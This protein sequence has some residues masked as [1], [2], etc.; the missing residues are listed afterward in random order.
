MDVFAKYSELTQNTVLDRKS[1]KVSQ[2]LGYVI[3][4]CS[5]QN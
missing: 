5:F 3:K 2:I 4:V 1:N